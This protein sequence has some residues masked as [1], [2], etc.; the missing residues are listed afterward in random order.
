L[1]KN[2][3]TRKAPQAKILRK[4]GLQVKTFLNLEE[5]NLKENNYYDM[6]PLRKF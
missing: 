4:I 5:I 6:G 2:T 3:E 1:T